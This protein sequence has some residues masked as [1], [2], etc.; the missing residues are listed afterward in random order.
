VAAATAA[1]SE[2]DVE[3]ALGLFDDAL[4][5][6]RGTPLSNLEAP[7]L[8]RDAEATLTELMLTACEQWAQ[9]C[10]DLGRVEAVVARLTALVS[11]HPFRE[12]LAGQL[13][14]ALFRSGRQAEAL[15][16]YERVRDHLRQ[17]LGVTPG[18]TLQELH[19]G[20]LRSDEQV[21]ETRVVVRAQRDVPRQ[22][23]AG[24]PDFTGRES[25]IARIRGILGQ[26]SGRI[27]VV[28]GQGGVGKTTLALHVAHQLRDTFPD[29]QL[30]ADLRGVGEQPVDPAKVLA[31]FLNELGVPGPS[32]P[33]ALDE[34]AAMF[35]SLLAG[36]RLL[37]LLD[38]AADEAQVRPLL[39]GDEASAVLV[40]S[41]RR[42]TALPGGRVVE[43]DVLGEDSSIEM[44]ERTI[45]ARRV[46]AEPDQA[47]SVVQLCGGLPL[48]LRIAGARLAARPHWRIARLVERLG[49]P[50]QRLSELR[51]ADLDVRA[52]LA[53]SFQGLEVA[54]K[55]MLRRIGVLDTPDFP[56]WVAAALLDIAIDD[57]D[58]VLDELVG[59]QLLEVGECP[60]TGQ[61]RYRCH[62]L[63]RL[64]AREQAVVDEPASLS[65]AAVQRAFGGWLALTE[66][67]HR[68]VYGGDFSI[69]HGSAPRWLPDDPTTRRLIADHPL[70][71]L[72][73]ERLALPAVIRQAAERDMDE[74]CWDLA[75]VGVTLFEARGYFD[76]WRTT[77]EQALQCT[78]RAGNSRGQAAILQSLGSLRISQH[79]YGAARQLC[80]QA[81]DLFQEITDRHGQALSRRRLALIDMMS[82]RL[83]EALHGHVEALKDFQDVGDRQGEA[84]TLRGLARIRIER[85]EYDEAREAITRALRVIRETGS[86]R[87]EAQILHTL[88][89][90]DLRQ[91]RPEEAG[92]AFRDVL[93]WTRA[94]DDLIGTAH[95][96]LALGEAFTGEQRL[97]QAEAHLIEA[98]GL[99]TE[100]GEHYVVARAELALGRLHLARQDRA[101]AST[102][103][104]RSAELFTELGMPIWQAQA[105]AALD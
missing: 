70:A 100:L 72:D 96:L 73:G 62:D 103:L 58:D 81:L 99:A 95:A 86:R 37:L 8:R 40:T 14:T 19:L 98:L 78:A 97:D 9:H 65:T 15:A 38:N 101:A 67:A 43:L 12:R 30:S 80:E 34:R 39:P 85:G 32:L 50:R 7:A 17:E 75:C 42:L 11:A 102:R 31:A 60:F 56:A 49:E 21:T 28:A 41:R 84:S 59:A 89:E 90:L 68:G 33:D 55:T 53:L 4:T 79:T 6:W 91:G 18:K 47:R 54:A 35:R 36:R 57:A 83:D 44:L 1:G 63:I 5:L 22:L 27:V 13:I 69:L 66:E 45:G 105:A 10:L 71:W 92:Q 61:A 26:N 104:R 23:S 94:A 51:H 46:A 3:G 64:F 20:I 16:A 87:G 24:I 29:G 77:H 25:E 48:A 93:R 2:G 52:T 88:G 76:D 74:L 82:G